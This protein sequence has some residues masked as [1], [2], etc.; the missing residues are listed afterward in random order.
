MYT[1]KSKVTKVYDGDTITVEVDLG[2]LS[3]SQT[4]L[5]CSGLTVQR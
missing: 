5:D 2:F 1:Y 3:N 4:L